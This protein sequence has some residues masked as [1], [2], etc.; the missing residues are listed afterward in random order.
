MIVGPR[1]GVSCVLS[2]L[3]L[4]IGRA[5][6][7]TSLP[8]PVTFPSSLSPQIV[9]TSSLVSMATTTPLPTSEAPPDS[10]SS[11]QS[12]TAIAAGVGGG[13][14]VTLVL[15]VL[16]TLLVILVVFVLRRRQNSKTLVESVELKSSGSPMG[17]PVYTGKKTPYYLARPT[18][19]IGIY[20]IHILYYPHLTQSVGTL[21]HAHNKIN[22]RGFRFGYHVNSNISYTGRVV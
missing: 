12:S 5:H 17:N 3:L 22:R 21:T 1:F 4:L 16:A 9:P 8:F 13:L 18:R 20:I 11:G 14:A 2:L 19:N 6:T 7:L 15:L 10:S